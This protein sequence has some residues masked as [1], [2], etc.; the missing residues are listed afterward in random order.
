MDTLSRLQQKFDLLVPELVKEIRDDALG[1]E[2]YVVVWDST[3][4][5]GGPLDRCGKGGTR[6]APDLSCDE[7]KMLARKMTL[8]NAAAGLPLG[9]SK[10][11]LKA[12]P[13]APDFEK[14]YRRFV[15]LCKPYLFE[16]GGIFGGFGFDI[17]AA[18]EHALWACD[19]LQSTQSFTG[20][21]LDMG[22]TDYDRE[23]L[24]GYGVAVA[25]RS[26]LR[27]RHQ[28][29]LK[30][31]FAVQGIGAM[32]AAVIRYFTE[33]GGQLYVMSDPR[34]GGAWQFDEKPSSELIALIADM[35]FDAINAYL[36]TCEYALK[37][38]DISDV[39]YCDADILFPCA[40]HDVITPSNVENIKALIIVE[41][42]NGPCSDDV[43][44]YLAKRDIFVVP[45]FLANSGGII[46]AFIELT[47]QATIE[48]NM[49]NK[50]KTKEAKE[51]TKQKISSNIDALFDVMK[52]QDLNAKDA[53]TYIA[54]SRLYPDG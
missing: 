20:K 6:I 8:K 32:G 12:D 21:P 2:G 48:D 52:E 13:K 40:I 33:F 4:S 26:V 54:L 30:S 14:K 5:V 18:P 10:S 15:S 11:G 38:N 46:A 31:R 3:L 23:G 50:T 16:N 39:L 51:L 1:V 34:I 7:V 36:S 49:K 41:G 25:A 17:G 27:N 9:G 28:D 43:Y 35:N 53:A 44:D 22:G 37:M 19:E 45:D 29:T 47:S 42:A 24:A